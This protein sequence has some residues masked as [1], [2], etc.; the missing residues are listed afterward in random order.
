VQCGPARGGSKKRKAAAL[1][2]Q[3]AALNWGGFDDSK[4]R[5]KT[6]VIVKRMF[7]LDEMFSDPVRLYKLNPVDLTHSLKAPGLNS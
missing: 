6:T 7:T 2:K 4:D 3:E 5:K 1:A